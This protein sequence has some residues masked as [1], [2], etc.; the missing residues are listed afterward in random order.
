M[1]HLTGSGSDMILNDV[2][3]VNEIDHEV[4]K[5]LDMES[6]IPTPEVDPGAMLMMPKWKK[7]VQV[8]TGCK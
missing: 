1:A 3:V 7:P 5:E 4:N 6:A 2:V 8:D